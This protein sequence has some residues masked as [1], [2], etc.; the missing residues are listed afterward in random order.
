MTKGSSATNL[1][2]IY[3]TELFKTGLEKQQIEFIQK[4]NLGSENAV[5]E[6][7]EKL[8]KAEGDIKQN[9][10]GYLNLIQNCKT[11]NNYDTSTSM[12][13]KIV[14]Q[15]VNFLDGRNTFE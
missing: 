1:V 4:H 8:S 3:K 11:M 14:R 13:K 15:W 2:E 10:V 12:N 7:K 6:T 5:N 9:I